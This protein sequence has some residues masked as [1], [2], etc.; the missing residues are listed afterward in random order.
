VR[1]LAL[2]V[3]TVVLGAACGG[4]TDE[5]ECPTDDCSI[6]GSTVV[7]WRFHEY[8]EWGFLADT[9]I[10]LGVAMVRVEAVHVDMP[11]IYF[12]AI[13]QCGEAQQTFLRLPEGTYDIVVTPLD[14]LGNPAVTVS[15]RGQVVAGV[16]GIPT[17][18]TINVPHTA[19]TRTYTGTFYFR[20][21]WAGMACEP[22]AVVSQNLKLMI[23]GEV[24]D[25]NKRLD[26]GQKLDGTDD[27]PCRSHTDEFAQFAQEL[28]FGPATL[29][30]TGKDA[31]GA[32]TYEHSFDTFIGAGQNNP[33][34]TF[35]VPAPP[36]PP[37]PSM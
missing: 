13:N 2:V 34:I 36:V 19:W 17:E 35:D 12:S 24:V 32:M 30:V 21:S 27:Q 7:K 26:N 31:L 22:A 4:G 20:L 18:T 37:P 8:P 9:C 33:T 25:P 23:G 14:E 15:A 29:V 3:A 5:P 1:S 16:P 6:P 11:E 10:D 28:P